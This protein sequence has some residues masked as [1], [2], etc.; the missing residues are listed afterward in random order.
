MAARHMTAIVPENHRSLPK[1]SFP[2]F[3]RQPRSTSSPRGPPHCIYW[4][5]YLVG[6]YI[7]NTL[8]ETKKNS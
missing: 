7:C 4:Y 6:V 2:C 1:Q 8:Y 3:K 5:I